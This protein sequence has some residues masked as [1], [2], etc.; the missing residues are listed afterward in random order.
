MIAARPVAARLAAAVLLLLALLVLF[1]ARSGAQAQT[2]VPLRAGWNN[3]AYQGETLPVDRALNDAESAVSAVWHWQAA[4]ATWSNYFPGASAI[5]SLVVLEAGEAYW[6]F[7]TADVAWSQPDAVRFESA[8]AELTTQSG[9]RFLLRVELADTA[10]RRSRGL[11]FRQSLD[12]ATGMLFLFPTLAQG[13]FW[14]KDTFVPLSIAF[15]DADGVIVDILDMEPLTTTINTPA[16]PYRMALEVNQGWF[17]EQGI[18]IG[19]RFALT[20]A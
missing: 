2:D 5:S 12:A 11:M 8:L 3:V 10:S 17:A 15:I 18:A 19:D 14:M 6:L 1:A 4:T 13:G 20:G 7:A 16:S 9:D